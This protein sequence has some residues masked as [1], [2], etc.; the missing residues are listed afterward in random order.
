M[1]FEC[2]SGDCAHGSK[3]HCSSRAS[4]CPVCP[5]VWARPP[6][7]FLPN[8]AN[9]VGPIRVVQA[10][11]E[12]LGG[13]A[14]HPRK[15]IVTRDLEAFGIL[16]CYRVG[17]KR[18]QGGRAPLRAECFGF[19][20]FGSGRLAAM[21]CTGALHGARCYASAGWRHG[22]AEDIAC[23]SCHA[24]TASVLLVTC[25]QYEVALM[26]CLGLQDKP[27]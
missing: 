1:Q 2:P 17:L 25:P 5:G 22:S 21:P 12:E 26:F 27:S 10:E 8:F 14:M 23:H 9:S 11:D 15:I 19:Q 7:Y 16:S 6:H 20:R 13:G 24:A 4:V 18:K 3:V